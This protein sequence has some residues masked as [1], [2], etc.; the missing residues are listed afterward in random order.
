MMDGFRED[1]LLVWTWGTRGRE[2][3]EWKVER[4]VKN[5]LRRF[6]CLLRPT[7]KNTRRAVQTCFFRM[8]L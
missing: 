3:T 1:R 5:L 4:L 6:N 7:K 2:R 8:L